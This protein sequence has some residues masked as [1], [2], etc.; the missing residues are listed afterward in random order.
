MFGTGGNT[1]N[2]T[3]TAKKSIT[4]KVTTLSAA[5]GDINKSISLKTN[6]ASNLF[7]SAGSGKTRTITGSQKMLEKMMNEPKTTTRKPCLESNPKKKKRHSVVETKETTSSNHWSKLVVTAASIKTKDICTLTSIDDLCRSN[8]QTIS[9]NSIPRRVPLTNSVDKVDKE[10]CKTTNKNTVLNNLPKAVISSVSSDAVDQKC[11]EISQGNTNYN[12][13]ASFLRVGTTTAAKRRRTIPSSLPDR[14]LLV[15]QQMLAQEQCDKDNNLTVPKMNAI[16]FNNNVTTTTKGTEDTNNANQP[17]ANSRFSSIL[18]NSTKD[19]TFATSTHSEVVGTNSTTTATK[20]NKTKA[21]AHVNENYVRLNMRNSSGTCRQRHTTSKWRRTKQDNNDTTTTRLKPQVLRTSVTANV[22]PLDDYFDGTLL[23]NRAKKKTNSHPK[24][25]RHGRTC[26]LLVVRKTGNNKGRKFY[27]CSL[28]RGEQCDF[29]QWA[30][31][32]VEA[33]KRLLLL[34][35]SSSSF[36]ARQVASHAARYKLLT[37]P[38]LRDEAKTRGLRHSGKKPEVLAR[39][40]VWV[41]DEISKSVPNEEDATENEQSSTLV[42]PHPSDTDHVDET[43]NSSE[44][45]ARRDEDSVSSEQSRSSLE[46]AEAHREHQISEVALK[47]EL[48]RVGYDT[49]QDNGCISLSDDDSTLGSTSHSSESSSYDEEELDDTAPSDPVLRGVMED[50]H[51]VLGVLYNV[52]GYKSFRSGQEWAVERCINQKRSLLVAPTGLGK[53]LCYALPA[54]VLDGLTIV[55]SPLI[56]LMQDQLRHLPPR[57]PSASLSGSISFSDMVAI[58]DDIVRNRIKILFVSPERLASAAFKRLFRG[59]GAKN[60]P[61]VSLLCI[62]ECHCLSTW[63]HNFRPSYLR[64]KSLLPLINPKSVLA[65]TATASVQVIPDICNALGIPYSEADIS[66]ISSTE[67]PVC[68]SDKSP[69]FIESGVK[70]LNVSRKNIDVAACFLSSEEMRRIVLLAI[71][72]KPAVHRKESLPSKAATS[73]SLDGFGEEIYEGCLS[74]GSVIVYVWRQRDAEVLAEQLTGAGIE[75]GVVYYHG[76]LERGQRERAQGQFIRGKARICVATVAF[77]MGINKADVRGVIH[78]CLPQSPENYVQEI[79]RAGRDGFPSKAICLIL[80]DE[81]CIRHSLA[82]SDGLS[83]SQIRAFVSLIRE[84]AL[85]ALVENHSETS[86]LDDSPL[87]ANLDIA[88]PIQYIVEALDCKEE[89]VETLVSI[90]EEIS[91]LGTPVAS[92][93]GFLPDNAVITLKRRTLQDLARQELVA[94][95]IIECGAELSKCNR[96]EVSGGSMELQYQNVNKNGGTASQAGFHA[97]AFGT[98]QFS[99]VGCTRLLGGFA[100][101]RNVFAALRRLQ[102]M[103]ELELTLDTGKTGRAMHLKLLRSAVDFLNAVQTDGRETPSSNDAADCYHLQLTTSIFERIHKQEDSCAKKVEQ[104]YSILHQV[105]ASESMTDE[106][107]E[108]KRQSKNDA[109]NE[110]ACGSRKQLLFQRLVD[111][112]F[113]SVELNEEPDFLAPPI[114]PKFSNL[115]RRKMEELTADV[116]ILIREPTLTSKR[117]VLTWGSM[118]NHDYT[119]RAIT[120]ILHAIDSPR[121]PMS[122][123]KSHPL[124]GKWR[125]YCFKDINKSVFSILGD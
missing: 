83:F 31:D 14:S 116:T 95:C 86:G 61:K 27:V 105:A 71:L 52:F 33:A 35:S 91:H 46:Q 121:A 63:G 75:G 94:R 29:F 43:L 5:A 108:G 81:V 7:L 114:H 59:G 79:G 97:Y 77:G 26:R 103:G 82:H 69:P 60:I 20:T 115:D 98:W 92:L 113:S 36:I 9:T 93:E 19:K 64:I 8:S 106:S 28:P 80:Q 85:Q 6:T 2:A 119:A 102:D 58:V 120:K 13:V 101:P 42:A 76:G 54:V 45:V 11:P 123:W 67:S 30:E 104:I 38:E 110:D 78:M 18:Q 100:E 66:S 87:R 34:G 25:I 112:Y 24:C 55:V 51:S 117:P 39:L 49:L 73:S 118:N 32:T 125:T 1:S 56:S 44:L 124:W 70:V 57:I 10:N 22:D 50:N 88:M 107:E 15:Q 4:A 122:N 74:S 3:S 109:G 47:E 17:P 23:N 89:S 12:V 65:L 41:R 90:L 99:V 68:I 40:L 53:S 111:R 16:D 84:M 21:V 62:D 37:L 48:S 96:P 72:K